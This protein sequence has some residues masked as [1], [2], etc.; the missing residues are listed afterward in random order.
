MSSRTS[1]RSAAAIVCSSRWSSAQIARDAE[2]V[3]D[4]LLARSAGLPGVSALGGL[5]CAPE[6]VLV[7]VR[8]VRLDLGD[9][10]F[11]EVF[12]MPLRVEDSS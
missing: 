10:L 9:Q 7:D 1:C 12:A 6:Q 11:D 4:E 3:V 8:V 2:R 5:E